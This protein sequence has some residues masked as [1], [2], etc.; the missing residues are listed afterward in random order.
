MF[1]YTWPQN[2]IH[3]FFLVLNVVKVLKKVLGLNFSL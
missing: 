2:H 1:I 3:P